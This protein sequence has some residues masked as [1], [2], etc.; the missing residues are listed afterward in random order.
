MQRDGAGRGQD[1][2]RGDAYSQTGERAGSHADDEMINVGEPATT[3]GQTSPHLGQQLLG[4]GTRVRNGG[5]C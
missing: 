4:M 2:R 5:D 3:I 1:L